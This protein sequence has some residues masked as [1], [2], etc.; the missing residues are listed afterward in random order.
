MSQFVNFVGNTA[1]PY[2]IEI[3]QRCHVGRGPT[4]QIPA[5]MVF[6]FRR[7]T[8]SGLFDP[9]DIAGAF[10][11]GW[12]GPFFA[13]VC[14]RMALEQTECRQMDDP[15]A[16]TAVDPTPGNGELEQDLYAPDTAIYMQLKTGFRG[17]SYFGSKHFAG[18]TETQI[19][20]GLINTG[21]ALLWNAVRTQLLSYTTTGLVDGAGNAWK[22]CVVSRVL[23]N[24]TSSPAVFTGAD[25]TS[26]ILNGRVGTMGRRRGDR[27]A[28]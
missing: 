4:E 22:L 12:N 3:V 25:V 27:V 23:S 13:A 1:N 15:T 20:E 2:F 10:I 5:I 11:G 17:R 19:T 16:A 14:D 18:A 8:N 6:N 21:G 24:L 7:L 28:L 26:I 9:A